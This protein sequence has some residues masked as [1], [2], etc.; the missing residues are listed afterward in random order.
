MANEVAT[1][2]K[3]R[4]PT[5]RL[6]YPLCGIYMLQFGFYGY[7]YIGQ[8]RNIE[9]RICEHFAPNARGNDELH[10]AI[11][12][13]G[14]ENVVVA[15][16]EE[17]DPSQLDER[18]KYYIELLKPEYNKAKGGRGPTGVKCSDEKKEMCRQGA[19]RQ[20]QTMDE[21]TKKRILKN[22][23]P[24]KKG[25][26]LSPKLQDAFKYSRENNGIPVMIEETGEVFNKIVDL[27]KY[28][29]ACDGTVA[30]Y[31]KGKIKSVKGYHVKKLGER[32]IF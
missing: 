7:R 27:E 21:E 18:E 16:L 11:Q 13:V 29:G 17:C 6:P 3:R 31:F 32:R 26:K 10:K 14:I 1:K 20:W 22:L 28:V 12:A 24:P 19:L 9:R 2:Q 15:I 4:S 23:Q 5:K 25:H 30:A 8:S